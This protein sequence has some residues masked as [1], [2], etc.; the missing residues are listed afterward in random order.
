M[1]HLKRYFK[2]LT[3]IFK[4]AIKF[5][6]P[7]EDFVCIGLDETIHFFITRHKNAISKNGS[8]PKVHKCS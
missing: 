8:L 4:K 6:I 5:Y 3:P 1:P 7:L 2:L